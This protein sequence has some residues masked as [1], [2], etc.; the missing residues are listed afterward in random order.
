MTGDRLLVINE[1][2]LR[3]A[4]VEGATLTFGRMTPHEHEFNPHFWQSEA[5]PLDAAMSYIHGGRVRLS[6]LIWNLRRSA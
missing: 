2:T 4:R 6:R 5:A 3:A 1:D